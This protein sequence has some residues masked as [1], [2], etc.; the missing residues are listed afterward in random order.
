MK[1][2]K[3]KELIEEESRWVESR[4]LP[5]YAQVFIQSEEAQGSGYSAIRQSAGS[6]VEIQD[7]GDSEAICRN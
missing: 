6:A 2:S 5:L 7:M 4:I 1:D 3:Q